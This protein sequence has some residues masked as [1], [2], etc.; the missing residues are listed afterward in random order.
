MIQVLLKAVSFVLCMAL[1][2][3]LKH[4]HVLR[5]DDHRVV[6]TIVTNVTLPCAIIFSF[7]NFNLDLSLFFFLL[8]PIVSNSILIFLAWFTARNK[9]SEVKV[10]QL[11]NFSNYNI[12]SFTLPFIQNF[13]SPTCVVAACLYDTPNAFFT[14]GGTYTLASRFKEDC[15][16]FTFLGFFKRIM[17]S[18]TIKAYTVLLILTVLHIHIPQAVFT[19]VAPA[20]NANAFMSMFMLGLYLDFDFQRETLLKIAKPLGIRLVVGTVLSFLIFRFVPLSLEL[21]RTA[22]L[23]LFAPFASL[24]PLYTEKIGSDYKTSAMCNSIGI[25]VS[26]ILFS[27]MLTVWNA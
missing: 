21:K 13:L 2:Y 14:M 22:M 9:S 8:L 16:T 25:V 11:T 6:S 7:Q 17:S 3:L 18:V 27:A 5:E 20:A 19:L 1:A 24:N 23:V 10:Y 4:S 26:M 15:P 12:G